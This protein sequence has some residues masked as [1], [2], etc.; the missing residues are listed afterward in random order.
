MDVIAAPCLDFACW[1][2]GR[3]HQS[4]GAFEIPISG[5]AQEHSHS[6]AAETMRMELLHCCL[7]ARKLLYKVFSDYSRLLKTK[8]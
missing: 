4:P 2:L 7:M 5:L 8:R 1:S 3:P 6:T